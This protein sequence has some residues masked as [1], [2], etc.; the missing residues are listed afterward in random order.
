[1]VRELLADLVHRGLPILGAVGGGVW[2][3]SRT[4][5]VWQV[6]GI[7]AGGWAA[8]WGASKALRWVTDQTYPA[9]PENNTDLVGPG[10]GYEGEVEEAEAAQPAAVSGIRYVNIEQ[11]KARLRREAIEKR[12]SRKVKM[13]A[14]AP[15]PVASAE[16]RNVALATVPKASEGQKPP[17]V[18]PL[19][20]KKGMMYSGLR[21][22]KNVLGVSRPK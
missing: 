3:A 15:A 22:G 12:R 17:N 1:M 7:A 10:T 21:V 20:G 14:A 11:E 16:E 19:A 9:L 8:G 18:V 4:R 2:A 5:P 6:L 13:P